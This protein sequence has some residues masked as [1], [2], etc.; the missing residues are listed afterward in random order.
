MAKIS[1]YSQIEVGSVVCDFTIISPNVKICKSFHL[2]RTSQVAHDCIVG[3]YVTCSPN[4]QCNGNVN[5]QNY[6]LI[7][8]GAI[9]KN[10]TSKEPIII[11]EKAII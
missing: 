10:G 1:Q 6:V 9:I 5:I 4:V 3:D 7:G 11:S 2:N 8:T